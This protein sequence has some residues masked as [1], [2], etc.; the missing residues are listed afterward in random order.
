MEIA[1]QFNVEEVTGRELEELYAEAG[2]R[3]R[4][5]QKIYRAFKNSSFVCIA[6][7][8]GR[9]VG[10]SRAITDGEYHGFIYDVAVRPGYQGR[11]IGRRLVEELL[12]R[13]PVWRVM[14]VARD[15]VQSFYCNLGFER[16]SNVMARLDRNQPPVGPS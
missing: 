16:Y 8:H 2:L 15:E 5:D 4:A 13:L 14:L 9:L 10:A 7:D 11:G 1:Y 12:T 6:C 3:R